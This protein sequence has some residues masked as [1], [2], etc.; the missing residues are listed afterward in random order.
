M[1][2]DPNKSLAKNGGESVL[3]LSIGK[4][5]LRDRSQGEAA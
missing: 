2:T 3:Q 4:W 1:F 5:K